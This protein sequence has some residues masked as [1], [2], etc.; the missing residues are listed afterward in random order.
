M[1]TPKA[2][3]VKV[4][5]K[6]P[7]PSTNTTGKG[8]MTPDDTTKALKNRKI[9]LLKQVIMDGDN[10]DKI[11]EM[12][13]DPKKMEKMLP[14]LFGN[15]VSFEKIFGLKDALNPATRNTLLGLGKGDSGGYGGPASE[16]YLQLKP[17]QPLQSK[18]PRDPTLDPSDPTK[19]KSGRIDGASNN[20]KF[21]KVS[22]QSENNEY[23][24]LKVFENPNSIAEKMIIQ[25][26]NQNKINPNDQAAFKKIVDSYQ[27]VYT[28][29]LKEFFSDS[30]EGQKILGKITPRK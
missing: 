26:E 14:L 16:G 30:D 27:K 2:P 1:G 23:E 13:A 19:N 24:F 22:Q 18:D 20:N 3:K 5:T 10:K 21:I 7:D 12:L 17:I 8:G 29:K 28:N 9:D 15:L 6:S 11:A 25:I 4:V